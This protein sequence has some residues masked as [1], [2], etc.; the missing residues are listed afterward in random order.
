MTEL[1]GAIFGRM[2][3]TVDRDHTDVDDPGPYFT[4]EFN[5]LAKED[6]FREAAASILKK[7]CE[8]LDVPIDGVDESA[9]VDWVVGPDKYCPPR[10]PMDF[11]PS[12]LELNSVSGLVS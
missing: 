10:H 2:T 1:S 12:F 11:K 6:S 4:V 5:Q 7:V 9:F 8:A 3:V